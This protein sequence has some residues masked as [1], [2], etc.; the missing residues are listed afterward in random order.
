MWQ[1]T[2]HPGSRLLIDPLQAVLCMHWEDTPMD[3]QSGAYL[4]RHWV[5]GQ[6]PSCHNPCTATKS[7]SKTAN[8]LNSPA[9]LQRLKLS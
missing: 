8:G 1:A 5:R 2:V 9:V 3:K 4:Q 6:K 7:Y